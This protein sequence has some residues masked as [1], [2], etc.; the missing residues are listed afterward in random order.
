[1]SRRMKHGWQLIVSS[2]VFLFIYYYYYFVLIAVVFFFL[3]THS[4]GASSLLVS[5]RFICIGVHL[6]PRLLPTASNHSSGLAVSIYS[7]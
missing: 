6:Y 1:M 3:L 2:N 4:D 5:H 7:V